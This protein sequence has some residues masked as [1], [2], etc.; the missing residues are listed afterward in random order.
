MDTRLNNLKALKDLY[1]RRL[2]GEFYG[3]EKG[4]HQEEKDSEGKL[5][6]TAFSL[7]ESDKIDV[8]SCGL[9]SRIKQTSPTAG[10]IGSSKL[11]FITQTPLWEKDKMI[12]N[13]RSQMLLDIQEKVFDGVGVDF[14]SFVKCGQISPQK[15]EIKACFVYMNKEISQSTANV[16]VC[17]GGV[18]SLEYFGFQDHTLF[19]KI[20]SYKNKHFI[21]THTLKDL[22]RNPSLKKETHRHLLAVK[23]M[24]S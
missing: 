8:K 6:G 2:F 12:D 18:E 23:G 1:L 7:L 21:I 10:I 19:G 3:V 5:G 11:I 14:L 13:R 24:L 16:A 22:I 9:C 17:F 4:R 20:I 15:E